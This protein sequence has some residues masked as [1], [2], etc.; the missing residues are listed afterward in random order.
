MEFFLVFFIIFI[1]VIVFILKSA[2]E[3]DAQERGQIRRDLYGSSSFTRDPSLNDN[4][5]FIYYEDFES[6]WI[7]S[8]GRGKYG[9]SNGF[10]YQDGPG[11]YVITVYSHPV[12]DDNWNNYE[13]IYIGQSVNVCQ[14][15]HNHFNGKGNGDVYADIKYGKYVYVHFVMCQESEMNDVEKRLIRA[16][17]AT[18]S[19][20][21]TC[22]G[23][24]KR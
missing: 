3:F 13:D 8:S 20:N 1:I 4:K 22:G 2:I 5:T 11:C 18:K 19:Y 21:K 24:A 23:S 10:K 17:N 7:I 14:R 12:T 9:T 6:R 16:F 15:V